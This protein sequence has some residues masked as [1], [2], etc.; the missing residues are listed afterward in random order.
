MK[1]YATIFLDWNK[2]LSHSKFWGHWQEINHPHNHIFK[3][4]QSTLFGISSE[5]INDWMRGKYTTE[6]I[7]DYVSKQTHQNY[8]LLWAGIH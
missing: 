5:R 3:N 6:Q 4:I 2:T 8:H 1:Q 7:I